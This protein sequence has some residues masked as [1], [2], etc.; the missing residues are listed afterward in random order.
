MTYLCTNIQSYLDKSYGSGHCVPFVQHCATAPQAK[1]WKKGLK[2]RDNDNRIPR[3]ATIATFDD[4]GHYANQ[5][6]GNHAAIYDG[7]DERGL[8][9]YDQFLRRQPEVPGEKVRQPVT[10]R[11][12]RF[13]AGQGSPSNDGDAFFVVE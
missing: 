4:N 9:V 11:H 6:T 13:R 3:G 5:P 8:W 12:I 7:Q 1:D 10:R 2:V